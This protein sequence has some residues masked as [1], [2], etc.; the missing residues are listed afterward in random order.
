MISD[1]ILYAFQLTMLIFLIICNMIYFHVFCQKQKAGT[2]T[3]IDLFI[4][5]KKLKITRNSGKMNI[6]NKHIIQ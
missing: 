5:Y 3:L 4:N 2:H 1:V 6:P